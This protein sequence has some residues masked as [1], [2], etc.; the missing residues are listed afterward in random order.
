MP[1]A[2]LAVAWALAGC[3]PS[4]SP[5][6]RDYDLRDAGETGGTD[7]RERIREALAETR[8]TAVPSSAPHVVAT[9][10]VTLQR[11]GLYRVEVSLEVA[12]IGDRYVRVFVHPYRKY[13]TGARRKIPYFKRRLRRSILPE[14]ARAFEA[15]GLYA[16]G[17]AMERD[18]ESRPD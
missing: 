3:A 2:I 5:L 13:F 17:S 12:P 8:W 9:D 15:Q 4:I 10:T 6:Y 7:M 16:I 18:K 1:A 11:W 14:L